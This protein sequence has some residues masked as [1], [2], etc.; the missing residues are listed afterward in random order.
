MH[1][2]T[3]AGDDI[4]NGS[5]LDDGSSD[6]DYTIHI[7]TNYGR[8]RKETTLVTSALSAS[9]KWPE[10]CLSIGAET[11]PISEVERKVYVEGRLTTARAWKWGK[12]EYELDYAD[13]AWTAKD[14]SS[15]S[16]K[17]IIAYFRSSR[18]HL[19]RKNEPARFVLERDVPPAELAFLLIALLYSEIRRLDVAQSGRSASEIGGAGF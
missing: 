14:L 19:F 4:L 17:T 15:S 2:L 18:S 13:G 12:I 16:H 10:R 9:I 11:H 8:I 5:L 6:A 1:T 7:N 3:F